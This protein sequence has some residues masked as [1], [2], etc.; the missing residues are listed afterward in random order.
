MRREL[1]VFRKYWGDANGGNPKTP[2]KAADYKRWKDKRFSIDT[3]QRFFGGW[4]NFCEEA[5]MN[6]WKTDEYKDEDIINL[7]LELWRWRGQRPVITDLKKY[8]KEHGTMLHEGTIKN[9]WGNWTPFLKLISQLG[10]GQITVEDVIAAKIGK[11]PREP[12]SPRLR[13]EILARDKYTCVDCG[14]SPR[15]DPNVTL[16][17]HHVLPVSEGGKSVVENLVTNCKTCNLGKSDQIISS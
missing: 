16:H 15:K 14:A 13:S 4:Q 6:P 1:S 9:K 2:V 3:L 10:Q 7:V 17:I 11:N 8:N 12:I 5:D